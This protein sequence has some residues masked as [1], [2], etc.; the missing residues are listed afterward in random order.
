[1]FAVLTF[2]ICLTILFGRVYL[3]VHAI[4]QVLFGGL[5]G[6]ILLIYFIFVAQKPL[7][8]Y[9]RQFTQTRCTKREFWVNFLIILAIMFLVLVPIAVIAFVINITTHDDPEGWK[10]SIIEK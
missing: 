3:G 7:L 6:L 2:L 4:G 9:F 1:V 10:Q 5:L 8:H